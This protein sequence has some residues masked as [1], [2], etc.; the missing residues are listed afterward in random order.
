VPYKRRRFYRRRFNYYDGN[1]GGQRNRFG[2]PLQAIERAPITSDRTFA[3]LPFCCEVNVV[4]TGA[5]Y[6]YIVANSIYQ[7]LPLGFSGLRQP[8]GYDQYEALYQDYMVHA[9]A[10]RARFSNGAAYPA[11]VSLVPSSSTFIAVSD[12]ARSSEHPYGQARIVAANTNENSYM[13]CKMTTKKAFG[14]TSDVNKDTYGA[15]FGFSPENKWYFNIGVQNVG[16]GGEV[17]NNMTVLMDVEFYCEFYN[18]QELQV[19]NI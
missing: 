10:I 16:G 15:V 6:V 4:T 3:V 18:R 8:R 2:R 14:M 17:A 1:Y 9:C 13:M 19:S 5:G 12:A 11:I 7:P